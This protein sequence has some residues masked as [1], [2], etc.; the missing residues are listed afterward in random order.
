MTLADSLSR[1]LTSKKGPQIQLAV[2]HIQFSEPRLNELR[3]ET[4][5]DEVLETLKEHI[6]RRF[7]ERARDIHPS[8]RPFWNFR[9]ELSIEDGLIIKGCQIIVP[10][11]D[12]SKS[13]TQYYIKVLPTLSS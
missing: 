13:Y 8:V 2:C 12:S 1:L 3:D 11:T 6:L 7:P 10:S 4:C 9:D 5:K